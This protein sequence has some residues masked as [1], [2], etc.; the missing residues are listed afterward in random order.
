MHNARLRAFF[1]LTF[2]LS[3]VF[4]IPTFLDWLGLSTPLSGNGYN[5]FAG[6]MSTFGP[7]AAALILLWRDGGWKSAWRLVKSAFDLRIKP[8]MLIAAIALPVASAWLATT[9]VSITGAD[10]LPD[11]MVPTDLPYPVVVWLIPAF[12]SMMIFGGGQEEFGWRGYAQEPMQ[13]RFGFVKSSLLLGAIWGLWHLPLW[14]IPGD[15]H[16]FIPF[17]VFVVFT[18]AFSVQMLWLFQLSGYKLAIPWIMHGVQNTV[19]IFL[20]V[21]RLD[22]AGPQF[23][24]YVYVGINIALAAV[25]VAIMSNRRTET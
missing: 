9:V 11:S 12:L 24:L 19:L 4:F 13:D 2:G 8:L 3:W 5:G 10:A 7:M 15:P 18:M 21:Y 20:P 22:D 6:F 14:I 23:G 17:L 1:L 25:A 16:I